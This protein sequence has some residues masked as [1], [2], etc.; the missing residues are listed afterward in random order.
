[1]KVAIQFSKRE[2]AKALP[3]LLRHS[4]GMILRNRIYVVSGEAVRA[5]RRAGIK[6]TE[7]S[8]EGETSGREG[9]AAGERI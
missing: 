4:P 6:F 8:R 5:L 2:E 7:M 3:I 1:M 9:V